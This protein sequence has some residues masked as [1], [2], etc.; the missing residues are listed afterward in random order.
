MGRR[1]NVRQKFASLLLH[2]GNYFSLLATNLLAIDRSIAGWNRPCRTPVQA[3]RHNKKT[4]AIP[5]LN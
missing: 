1:V 4:D 5:K 3:G 2:V